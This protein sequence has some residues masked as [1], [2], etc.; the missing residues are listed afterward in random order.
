[1]KRTSLILRRPPVSVLIFLFFLFTLNYYLSG[2]IFTN[3]ILY[4]IK[5]ILQLMLFS[6]VGVI[7]IV[8]RNQS[9]NWLRIYI[10]FPN[11]VKYGLYLILILGI[12][13]AIWAPVAKLAVLQIALY[14]MIF[15]FAVTVAA[16]RIDMGEEYDSALLAIILIGSFVYMFVFFLHLTEQSVLQVFEHAQDRLDAM[17]Q[18]YQDCHQKWQGEMDFG[19]IYF[20]CIR[21][22]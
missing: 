4:D 17:D 11:L 10:S 5:R 7:L 19:G 3:Y 6:F 16:Q 15:I 9:A 20:F 13:S 8:A 21:A 22:H 14:M 12:I 2:I 1:M 18:I